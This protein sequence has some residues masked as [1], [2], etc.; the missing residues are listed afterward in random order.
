MKRF[1]F[2]LILATAVIVPL[3]AR[4][5]QTASMAL[6]RHATDPNPGLKSYTASAV[7]SATLH[8]LLPVHKTFN[9][10][11]YYLKPKRKIDFQNVSGPL[12][13]FKELAS[14]VPTFGE[15]Q[16]EYTVTPLNDNGAL[17][18]YSLAPKKPGGRVKNVN[19]AVDDTSGL[20]QRVQWAYT[21]GGNLQLDQTYTSVGTFHLP[22][23]ANISARFPGYSVNGTLTFSNYSPNA[24]VSPS[25]FASASPSPG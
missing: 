9:G 6:L 22:S 23:A 5:A 25:V 19:L 21:N 15:L 10:T 2:S 20:I 7:L 4:S 12:A 16:S 24:A 13:R 18:N 3:D 14:S 8:A 17:S 1:A 11:V